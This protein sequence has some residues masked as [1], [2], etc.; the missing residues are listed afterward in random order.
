MSFLLLTIVSVLKRFWI[1]III[2][3]TFSSILYYTYHKG[4]EQ[5]ENRINKVLIEDQRKYETKIEELLRK[6]EDIVDKLVK[7][8]T[9]EMASCIL[10][11]NPF[12]KGCPK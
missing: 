6:G 10:S 7:D 11:G 1:P 4:V 3:F 12:K 5:C 8:P 9:D 2:I